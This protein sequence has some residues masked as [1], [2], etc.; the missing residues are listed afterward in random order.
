MTNG[1]T[2]SPI[3]VSKIARTPA[4][5]SV[6]V[7]SF[8]IKYVQ[9]CLDY[10]YSQ[11]IAERLLE[12]S[13]FAGRVFIRL[14]GAISI[15][16]KLNLEHLLRTSPLFAGTDHGYIYGR[17]TSGAILPELPQIVS[18]RFD[19]FLSQRRATPLLPI[20]AY[21]PDEHFVPAFVSSTEHVVREILLNYP[22]LHQLVAKPISRDDNARSPAV[23]LVSRRALKILDRIAEIYHTTDS[24]S[25]E[26]FE[27]I[28]QYRMNLD[29]LY[30]GADE[31]H[32]IERLHVAALELNSFRR[33]KGALSSEPDHS[34][35]TDSQ[36]LALL[37][38]WSQVHDVLMT[39]IIQPDQTSE[40]L[41]PVKI[42]KLEGLVEAFAPPT[43]PAARPAKFAA[44]PLKGDAES[45]SH[46]PVASSSLGNVTPSLKRL[47]AT[48]LARF[49]LTRET[50]SPEKRS[51][52]GIEG[53][54]EGTLMPSSYPRILIRLFSL[55][56]WGTAIGL[57][58]IAVGLCF[59]HFM[60][61]YVGS[62][63][64]A[65]GLSTITLTL[66]QADQLDEQHSQ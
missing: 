18:A 51:L 38:D 65:L 4:F 39:L 46:E 64:L 48:K 32:G 13:L 61:K 33:I 44:S 45:S 59:D 40:M 19:K 66:I 53:I 28:N 2:P 5:T 34:A 23:S 50:I 43:L 12:S 16:R 1:H 57:V 41:D 37:N 7:D 3:T 27:L 56:V 26:L 63:L 22:S 36:I 11:Q 21:Q 58:A 42:R 52:L 24:P 6:F 47:F 31:S 15:Y 54:P 29:L 55:G 62:G 25:V 60:T 8:D 30:Q 9:K 20:G 49:L 14:R 17:G 35:Q 10:A